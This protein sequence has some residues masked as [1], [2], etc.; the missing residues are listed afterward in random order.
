MKGS[1]GD[2]EEEDQ[3]GREDG[4]MKEGKKGTWIRGHGRKERQRHLSREE[5]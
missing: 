3:G 2:M 5:G 4:E 1:E